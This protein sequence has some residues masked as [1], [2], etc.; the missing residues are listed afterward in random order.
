MDENQ[1]PEEVMK[2]REDVRRELEAEESGEAPVVDVSND[3]PVVEK[4]AEQDAWQGVSPAVKEMFDQLSSKVSSLQDAES[5]LKQAESRIGSLSNK[6]HAAEKAAE[7]VKEAPT[8]AQLAAAAESDEKWN[9]LKADYP[10]WAEAFDSRLERVVS[11][12]LAALKKEL[13]SGGSE[14]LKKQV[15]TLQTTLAEGTQVEVQKGILAFLKPDWQ[16]TVAKKEYQE[17][18]ASQPDDI[19][20]LVKSQFAGDAVKVLDK[21]EEETG[22]AKS[23]EEIALERKRRLKSSGIPVGGKAVPAKS[24]AEMS[25]AELR[26]SIGKEV[27]AEK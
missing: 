9:A 3:P 4:P 13:G 27:F 20:A 6:L 16:K 1:T 14:E 18:L 26:Q 11:D 5:R 17:W 10:D 7:V 19:K 24:E 21:F 25:E 15:E 22:N 23:A 2:L 12:R 8:Q